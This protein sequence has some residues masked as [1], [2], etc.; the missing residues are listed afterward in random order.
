MAANSSNSGRFRLYALAGFLCLWLVVIC[1]R[2]V[3]LQI[4]CYGDF[5]RRAQHQQQRSFELSSRRG[6]IYDRAG[7]E[8]AMSID[9]DSAFIVPT[10]TPDLANTVSLIS[11]IT[12]DDPRV[13]LADC[14]AHKTFCWVARKADAETVERIRSLNLQGIHFQKEP[15][16]FYPKRELAAQ[17]LGYVGTDDQGLSGLEREFNDQLQGKPGK[18]MISVDARK[19]WFASVEKESEP[20]E[21]LVLTIDQ[22]IQYIAERELEREMEE[23]KAIA[24]TVV[25]MNPHTGEILALTNRP[26]FNPNDRKEIRPETLKNHAVSDVYEPGSTFKVVTVSAGLEEKV[27]RPDELFDCQ[28]GSIVI[29]GTRIHDSKP[30][31]VLSVSDIIA[32]SSDVGAIK[33]AMRLGNDRFYKY[34]RAFGFGQ[35][36]GIELPGETRGLAKPVERWSKISFA[37]ISMGQEVG[38]S[39]VQLGAL[40]STIANDGIRVPPRIVA[41]TAAPQN[42]LQN[43]AFH[44]AEG[45]RVISPLTA[46][47]MKQMLQGVVI[48]GTGRKALLEGYTSAGKTGTAQKFDPAIG[49]YSKTKYY[50]SF[51]GFAPINNPQIAVVVVLD[52]AVG[53]HQ[54]G[55]VAAPVFQRIVQQVLEY[56]HVPHDVELPASRQVLLARRNVPETS[57]DESSPDHL[58]A[59]LDTADAAAAET[60][61]SAAAFAKSNAGVGVQSPNNSSIA[62]QIV[63]AAQNQRESIS[64]QGASTEGGP[65]KPSFGLSGNAAIQPGD[66][67]TKSPAG[68]TVVLA[69]E[70]GGI[71]VP[72]FLGKNVRSAL[73]AAQDAGLDLDAIGSGTA[74]EQSPQPGA[75]VAAGARV[76]VRFAR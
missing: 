27:T 14:K 6:I 25:V 51:A 28:M 16:R 29:N 35:Q 53:L 5:E 64:P 3:Y 8:L 73:E 71:E 36:T 7:H 15:K 61:A 47:Q 68:T 44:P 72:S 22:N 10:E 66:A 24:G 58:G 42:G 31:G 17:V 65:F 49:K 37:S 45:T 59:S 18:L 1:L 60:S 48:H 26:T 30:H 62:A 54:G 39:A 75:H 20:G 52:S 56:Q 50:G 19:R 41:G 4:F 67:P 34:I 9:V 21:N 63:P 74:R 70:E 2:L 69:V 46:A 33:V 13:V 23:T 11:R 12:K 57:L 32:E 76:V 40:I 55:Q 38:V 43:V